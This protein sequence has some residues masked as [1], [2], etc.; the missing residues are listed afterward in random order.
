ME[1]TRR[2]L[3]VTSGGAWTEDY[4]QAANRIALLHFLRDRNLNVH[5]VFLYFTGDR[6]DLGAPG[7][8]CPVSESG[9]Q[10]AIAAQAAHLGIDHDAPIKDFIHSLFLPVISSPI[11]E[12]ALRPDLVRSEGR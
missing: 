6:M 3:G 1:A 2:A 4:Y 9:W 7:R 5:L 12:S 8:I 10:S 11:A